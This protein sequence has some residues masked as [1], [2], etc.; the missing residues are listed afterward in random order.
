[1]GIISFLQSIRD[2]RTT[3]EKQL[4]YGDLLKMASIDGSFSDDEMEVIKQIIRVKGNLTLGPDIDGIPITLED[5]LRYDKDSI[6]DLT[7]D[8][9]TDKRQYPKNKEKKLQYLIMVV[10]VMLADGECTP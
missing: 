6:T 9:D 2:G 4:L 7:D 8:W 1:M 5:V 10:S 3:K